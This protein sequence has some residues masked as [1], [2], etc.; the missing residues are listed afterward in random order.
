[1]AYTNEQYNNT[2]CQ[3]CNN[4]LDISRS[5]NITDNKIDSDTPN[6]V[7][8][9]DNKTTVEVDYKSIIQK[10]ENNEKLTN[11]ELLSIDFN[12]LVKD[13]YYKK[14][15]TKSNIKKTL[16][17]MLDDMENSDNDKNGFLFC[18]NCNY[19]RALDP[20]TKI[21]SKNPDGVITTQEYI[22]EANYRNKIHIRTLPRTRNFNCPNSK[23][24][25]KH[26]KTPIEAIFFRKNSFSYEMVYV[27]VN[28]LTIKII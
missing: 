14:L 20:N 26:N 9:A 18:N 17:N 25:G 10:L 16:M 3:N 28:C 4:T 5:L 8:S 13:N 23:C 11:T 1:M 15:T 24:P 19:S 6:T 27:C 2:F 21:M 12:D 7:T 22:N